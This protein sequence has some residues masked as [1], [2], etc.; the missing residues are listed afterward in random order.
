MATPVTVTNEQ[1]IEPFSMPLDQLAN[2]KKQQ[3]DD[4]AE[5]QRQLEALSGAR[6]RYLNARNTLDDISE[7]PAGKVLL[8]PLNQSLYVPGRIVDPSKVIVELG[9][10]YYCEKSISG[11]KD[12]IDRK[13]KL[14]GTSMETVESVLV[15]K[16]KNIEQLT[17]VMQYKIQMSQE[18][19]NQQAVATS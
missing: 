4:C 19:R 9:T 15:Q 14:V 11:S 1:Q 2:V 16:R 3:E 6:F 10:G 18:A 17:M 5:L 12:V 8:V 13:I 7:S